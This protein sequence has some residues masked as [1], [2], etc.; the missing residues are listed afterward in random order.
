MNRNYKALCLIIMLMIIFCFNVSVSALQKDSLSNNIIPKPLSYEKKEESFKLD[1]DTIIYFQGRNEGE[2]QDLLNICTYMKMKFMLPTG[3]DLN[4]M[5]GNSPGKNSIFL[6]TVNSDETLGIEGYDLEVSENKITAIAN[7]PEG[8][9]RAVQTLIQ[10]LPFQIEEKRLVENVEW[11]VP[12]AVIEDKPENVYRGFM[13]DVARHFFDVET[14]KKQIDY[15][16]QYKI[17]RLHLHLSDDQGWR[18]EIKRYP[19]LTIIGGSTEV[20]GGKGGYYTQEQFKELVSYAKERYIEI[21]PEFDMPGH[22]NAALASYGFLN[23]DGKKKPLYTGINIGF[24]S[25]MTNNEKTYEFINNVFKEVA[26]ISPSKYIHI[27]GDEALSTKKEDYDYFVGRVSKI[28]AKYD[29]IPIGWD[30]ID[31]APEINSSVVLEN[32]QN[33][34]EAAREKR[35]KMIIAIANKAYLDMKYNKETPYGLDWAGYIPIDIAYNW[36]LTDYAPKDLILGIEAPLWTETISTVEEMEYMIYPRLLGYAEIGWTPKELRS[37][38]E[39]KERLKAQ[40]ERLKVEGINFYDDKNI[41][42]L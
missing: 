35:M 30:P 11:I 18:L 17:N 38:D 28:A 23:P 33:S 25:F 14:I 9:F 8:V 1:R 37:F 12:G 21:I 7:T 36:D 40:G 41:F 2:V 3:F 31:T 6:T 5:Q 13:I 22:T 42:N 15:A 32:W 10:M 16:S 24:S 27:G 34:N 19:D 4:I 20:G 39:Y 29:K 26:E